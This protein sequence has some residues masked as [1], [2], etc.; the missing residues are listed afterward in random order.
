MKRTKISAKDV[1]GF[2]EYLIQEYNQEVDPFIKQ[3]KQYEIDNIE[4]ILTKTC[5]IDYT[6]K[7]IRYIE[8]LTVLWDKDLNYIGFETKRETKF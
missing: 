4:T 3:I 6:D 1:E 8:N 7:T 2:K 5:D